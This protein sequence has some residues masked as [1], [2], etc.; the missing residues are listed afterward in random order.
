[1]KD[2]WAA[3]VGQV[4]AKYGENA[5]AAAVCCNACRTCV[6]TNIVGIAAAGVAATGV[7]LGRFVRHLTELTSLT[8]S[9][10]RLR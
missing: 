3:R 10:D 6:T 1:M 9:R 7:S 4:A 2:I 5:P 8:P